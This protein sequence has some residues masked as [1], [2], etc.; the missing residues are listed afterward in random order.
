MKFCPITIKNRTFP[1]NVFYAPLAGFSD[2]PFRIVSARYAPGLMFCEMVK[3]EAL[4]RSDRET[5]RILGKTASMHPIG[6]QLCGSSPFLAGRAARILEDLGFDTIDLNCGC[7]VEKVT[8]DGSGSALLL[9][10]LLIGEILSNIV[11]A[12][13]IPVT[14][15]IRAGWDEKRLVHKDLVRIA[16]LAG[17]SALTIHARTQTQG[18]TGKANRTWIQ[19]AKMSATSIK[20]IGNGDIFS[21]HD[22]FSMLQETGCDGVLIAR[23][24]LGQPWIVDDC[25]RLEN[26]LDFNRS[27]D[28]RKEIFLEHVRATLAYLPDEQALIDLRR[29][30]CLYLTKSKEAR[31]FK[32]A[33]N[34]V[35]TIEEMNTLI[36]KAPLI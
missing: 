15:K 28:E 27:L 24:T 8:K 9:K 19:E 31:P 33:L 23:G 20:V 10:P 6:A 30:L 36:Q 29:V 32:E 13:K 1:I 35:S 5:F 26:G 21:A 17:A 12:V 4:V 25:R 16:E 11:A 2:V 7:P 34:H 18:Y 22:A 14:V 3:M